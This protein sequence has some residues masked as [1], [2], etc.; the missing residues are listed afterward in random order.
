MTE[1][2]DRKEVVNE[3][4]PTNTL[5]IYVGKTTYDKSKTYLYFTLGK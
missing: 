3:E 2:K 4:I 5:E 1:E